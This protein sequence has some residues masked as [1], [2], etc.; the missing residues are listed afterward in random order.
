MD[1]LETVLD[2]LAADDLDDLVAPQLLE[3]T[4]RLLRARNRLDAIL[5]GTL[6]RAEAARAAEHDGLT[7]MKGWLRTHGR[8]A[9]GEI[10]RL[11]RN[12]RAREQLPA[13]R[14]A[15]AAGTVTAEQVAV[16]APVASTRVQAEAVGQGIDLADLDR[17]LNATV[18]SPGS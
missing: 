14:E 12:G 11:I 1:E 8:L 18:R 5:T 9:A 17:L 2:A 7:S 16:I 4:A 15:F 3:R 13:L 6:R 10:S